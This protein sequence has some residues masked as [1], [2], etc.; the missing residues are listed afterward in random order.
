MKIGFIGL[1]KMG[2][3]MS[4]RLVDGG[5]E[6]V[7]HDPNPSARGAMVD[8][9]VVTVGSREELVTQLPEQLIWLMIPAQ[10]VDEELDALLE[11]VEPGAIIVD[12]GN[13]DYRLS[14]QRAERA[15]QAEVHYLDVGTSGGILGP[16]Q[17]Y[18]MMIGG[19]ETAVESL[20]PIFDALAPIDG[21]HH[22]GQS[23]SGHFVKMTHNAIEYGLM[24]S[25]AEGY[26]LLQDGPFTN[27]DLAAA[28]K[29][30]Q[31]GSI[32]QSLLNQ[33]AAEVLDDD[34][35]LG[36]ID[37]VVAESGETRWALEVAEAESISMPVIQAAFEVRLSSQAGQTNFAT[38]LIAALRNKF[39]GHDINEGSNQ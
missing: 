1:G 35:T 39:G 31:H 17:G 34:P 25:Y 30:W 38:K 21:W 27:I 16:K 32:I 33:L 29:V 12:G 15:S 10:Y 23:G 9:G 13:S 24:Q 7:A 37:G 22:F 20:R 18:S 36:G 28:G 4:R 26:R 5:H 11:L 19:D 6:V 2:G 14:L 8:S 3:N